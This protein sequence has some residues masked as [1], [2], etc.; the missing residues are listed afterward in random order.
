MRPIRFSHGLADWLWRIGIASLLASTVIALTTADW[1][2]VWVVGSWVPRGLHVIGAL[3]G[4]GV[5]S[6]IVGVGCRIVLA[7]RGVARPRRHW[8]RKVG[9]G[10]V[11]A[12][13]LIIPL[14]VTALVAW[15]D[16][17]DHFTVLPERSATGCRLVVDEAAAYEGIGVWVY[18]VPGGQH[19]AQE[20]GWY[21][22]QTRL[23]EEG[24]Y[25]LRW[26]GESADLQIPNVDTYGPWA[27][28]T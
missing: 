5:V 2:D 8:V 16:S 23:V 9:T 21:T 22:S 6:L 1:Q 20:V 7:D 15:L 24:R 27:C 3:L 17:S 28:S 14:P 11:T 19:R 10:L 13:V 12:F 18:V 4:V 26:S 25:E